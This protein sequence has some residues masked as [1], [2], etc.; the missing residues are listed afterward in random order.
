MFPS[1]YMIVAVNIFFS[2][3]NLLF[4]KLIVVYFP[5]LLTITCANTNHCP[6]PSLL[7]F[8][9]SNCDF[10][11]II[12]VCLHVLVLRVNISGVIVS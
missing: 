8:V 10:L 1:F 7:P 11:F 2:L 9:T 12:I 6:Q 5:V 3:Y 4:K